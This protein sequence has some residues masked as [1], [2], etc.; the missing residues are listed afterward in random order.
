[1]SL[2]DGGNHQD[3][4]IFGAD[5]IGTQIMGLRDNGVAVVIAAGNDFFTHNSEQ[6]MGYPGILRGCVSVGAVYDNNEGGFS[7]GSGAQAFS[8]ASD[9]ITPFSQRLHESVT[10]VCRTDIFAPGAPVTSSGINDD[11]GESVQHGTSQATPVT[12]GVLLLMQHFYRNC[13]ER[14]NLD[15]IESSDLVDQLVEWLRIS[16]QRINDGDNEDDNV[17]NTGLDFIRI[18][19]LAA[20]KTMRS[21]FIERLAHQITHYAF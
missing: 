21:Q 19:A 18:D 11:Q 4:A 8:T 20:L 1:M 17:V 13:V 5:E 2:G 14:A 10:D 3:D 16:G 12:T 15:D 6:G 7:Y 9:H